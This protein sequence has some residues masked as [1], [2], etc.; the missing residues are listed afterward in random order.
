MMDGRMRAYLRVIQ[1]V[2]H[3]D[4]LLVVELQHPSDRVLVALPGD[5]GQAELGQ[6]LLPR[7]L[8]LG[9]LRAGEAGPVRHEHPL[10]WITAILTKY[11]LRN[12][13]K[14]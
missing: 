13:N 7:V 11:S 5:L 6:G 8:G 14:F 2:D 3:A 4:A 12:M 10:L 1:T 9:D